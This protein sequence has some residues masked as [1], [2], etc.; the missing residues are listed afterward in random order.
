[1]DEFD[2]ANVHA[3]RG[4]RNQQQLRRQFKLATDDQLLLVAARKRARRQ[5]GVRRTH[6]KVANYLFSAAE[7]SFLI[8]QNSVSGHGGLAIV[9]AENRVLSQTEI[10]QQP[11]PVTILRDVRD[12]QLS[13]LARI[14]PGDVLAFEN[15]RSRDVRTGNQTGQRFDQFGLP[16][17]LNARD[18]D[19]F[20]G[21]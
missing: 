3:P 5:D 4:L 10:Q 12:A 9:N 20:A 8:Q 18:A 11:A 1:M 19:Y 6:I 14:E 16:V 7:N 2:R 21:P 17:A 15:H 13:S